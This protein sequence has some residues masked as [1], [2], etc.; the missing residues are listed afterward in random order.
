M[1]TQKL[2]NTQLLSSSTNNNSN[3]MNT[4]METTSNTTITTT[5][6]P[7]DIF[8]YTEEVSWYSND[9]EMQDATNLQSTP[10]P[11]ILNNK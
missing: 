7:N 2:F 11:P 4:N 9:V 6:Y 3:N 8:Q 5:N 10:P 1:S